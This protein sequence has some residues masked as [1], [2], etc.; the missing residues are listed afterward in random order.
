MHWMHGIQNPIDLILYYVDELR[1]Q[2]CA[3]DEK[4]LFQVCL[5]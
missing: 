3:V 1:I 5:H 2:H 4:V